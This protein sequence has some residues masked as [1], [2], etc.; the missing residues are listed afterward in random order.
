MP[1]DWAA[2]YITRLLVKLAP[3]GVA[4]FSPFV[5]ALRRLQA[6]QLSFEWTAACQEPFNGLKKAL[7]DAPLLALLDLNKRFALICDAFGFGLGAVLMH[8][9]RP[10]AFESKSLTLAET[11]YPVGEQ[12]LLAVVHACKTWSCYL[13]GH[14]LTVVADHSPKTFFDTKPLL[15]GRLIRWAERLSK[16]TF[17]W[18]SYPG[19]L[20]VADPLSR[21][22][23]STTAVSCCSVGLGAA[24]ERA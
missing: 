14:D 12:E 8:E 1:S 24:T 21:L 18:E 15:S 4:F 11:N 20:N 19:R 7:C 10:C 3:K 9:E 23:S 2:W 22:P 17:I 5:S 6:R 16:L 13:D